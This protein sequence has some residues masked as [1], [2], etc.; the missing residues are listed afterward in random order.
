VPFQNLFYPS[1]LFFPSEISQTYPGR[2][3][4]FNSI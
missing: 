2:R 4:Y 3:I 1:P